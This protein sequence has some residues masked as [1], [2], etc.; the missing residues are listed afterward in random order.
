[1]KIHI[2]F[3]Q[4]LDGAVWGDDEASLGTLTLGTEGMLS[5]LEGRL[6]L[7]GVSVSQPERIN[8]YRLK[9]ENFLAQQEANGVKRDD[10][11]A[12]GSFNVD[13]WS[14]A[15]Q[16]L[17]WRDELVE[18]LWSPDNISDDRSGVKESNNIE[19]GVSE[20]NDDKTSG[21]KSDIASGG[22]RIETLAALESLSPELGA[23]RAD[24]LRAVLDALEQGDFPDHPALEITLHEPIA[25]FQAIWRL[26]LEHLRRHGAVII[27]PNNLT[28][29]S[30]ASGFSQL[31]VVAVTGNDQLEL[32]RQAARYLAAAPTEN[33]N[34]ALLA[35][36]DSRVLD[37]MLRRYGF[38]SVGNS[39]PSAA[40]PSLEI[41]PLF[42]ETIWGPFRPDRLL[43]LLQLPISPVP[44]VLRRPLLHAVQNVPGIGSEE[45][46]AVWKNAEN[47]LLCDAAAEKEKDRKIAH[48]RELRAFLEAQYAPMEGIPSEELTRRCDWLTAALAPRLGDNNE[49][50]LPLS[51]IKTLKAIAS[52]RSYLTRIELARILDSIISVGTPSAETRREVTPF[53]IVTDPGMITRE[54]ETLLWF[55]FVR[56]DD[57]D[58]TRWNKEEIDYFAQE[59]IP[60][61]PTLRRR[62]ES[63]H[64]VAALQRT[65]KRLILFV[66]NQIAGEE[67]FP[68]PFLYDLAAAKTAPGEEIDA[69]ALFIDAKQIESGGVWRLA[70]RELPLDL[71]GTVSLS[72]GATLLETDPRIRTFSFPGIVIEPKYSFSYSQLKELLSCPFC[73][74]MKKY[75][76]LEDRTPTEVG[77]IYL[78][79]GNLTHKIFERLY[80]ESTDWEPE[81][82]H[83]RAES[84]YSEL[85]PQR[86]A[87]LNYIESLAMS[88][89][90][91]EIIADAAEELATLFK[92]WNIVQV[93]TEKSFPRER[94]IDG[95]D[96]NG[97][98]DMI[99]TDAAGHKRIIDFK[100]SASDH[101]SNPADE[102]HLQLA[103]Y[104]KLIGGSFSE[105]E[106]G[107][108]LPPKKQ[109]VRGESDQLLRIWQN[110]ETTLHRHL[111]DMKNGIVT[112]G[113][114]SLSAGDKAAGKFAAGCKYC[115][116]ASFCGIND[117]IEKG[118]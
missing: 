103:V 52:T 76:G 78:L 40:R 63:F 32:A 27:E 87:E 3:G 54:V 12:A 41:L 39:S 98:I 72:S 69:N 2:T 97:R 84:L 73:W 118:L 35:P 13:Y 81:N 29:N 48:L 102:S 53:E 101:Y 38:G 30:A 91:R 34:V 44:S 50:S 6:G 74:V 80:T 115:D 11:W 95:H 49:L 7:G 21:E 56:S 83:K 47:T 62:L 20:F 90:N 114:D 24:R 10:I 67:A 94:A 117:V 109:Y 55:D 100:S 45:W 105:T 65:L 112:C 18:E 5:F 116:F 4:R 77:N 33:R 14:T 92:K 71:A 75:L 61:D 57:N 108:Y 51:H 46:I 36:N 85:I 68:H 58:A 37:L 28:G 26:I 82:I 111:E 1:M 104:I 86:A 42:L 23:G 43:E 31:E 16:L 70:D 113:I 79:N 93:E 25:L 66:P 99:A 60:V 22:R 110:A 89:S 19:S 106:V 96:L 107:F 15:K 17:A 59:E 88:Q 64:R 8:Q 9:Y